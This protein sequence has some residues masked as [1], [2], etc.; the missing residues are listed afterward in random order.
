M[1]AGLI[2]DAPRYPHAR[3]TSLADVWAL[4]SR[5]R[6]LHFGGFVGLASA[7]RSAVCQEGVTPWNSTLGEGCY[8]TILA[9]LSVHLPSA[10]SM[11]LEIAELDY[12]NRVNFDA[13][14][15][16]VS[17]RL[18]RGEPVSEMIDDNGRS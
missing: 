14:A 6:H 10:E 3:R 15:R 7:D 4:G 5:V 1:D 9:E 17:R 13:V 18:P 16:W 2:S 8:A 12:S 11:T